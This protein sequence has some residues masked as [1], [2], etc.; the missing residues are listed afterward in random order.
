MGAANTATYYKFSNTKGAGTSTQVDTVN[1]AKVGNSSTSAAPSFSATSLKSTSYTVNIPSTNSSSNS[2]TSSLQN[3]TPIASA[4][5]DLVVTPT[6]YSLMANQIGETADLHWLTN[7]ERDTIEAMYQYL[8][9]HVNDP[10]PESILGSKTIVWVIS[11]NSIPG[12]QSIL[13]QFPFLGKITGISIACSSPGA[14]NI[15]QICRCSEES[16]SST[17]PVWN[18]L[19]DLESALDVDS[20][21]SILTVTTPISVNINDY[22]SVIVTN[23]DNGHFLPIITP[24]TV[25]LTIKLL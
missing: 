10:T 21:S 2:S 3:T 20:K 5:N 6:T 24:L 19:T 22:F 14:R 11:P 15:V 13:V 17:T 9:V 16:Y 4:G 25:E 23:S 8:K 18:V 12:D 1:S 7:A